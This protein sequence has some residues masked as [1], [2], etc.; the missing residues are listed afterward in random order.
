MEKIERIEATKNS[1]TRSGMKAEAPVATM[2]LLQKK[3]EVLTRTDG[4]DLDLRVKD[5]SVSTDPAK[6]FK[7]DTDTY[8]CSG[9]CAT[10][11]GC[12]ETMGCG[13]DCSIGLARNRPAKTVD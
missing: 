6:L 1:T 13:G 11:G 12:G 9:S 7:A 8:G 10:C 4:F 2:G 5:V 3:I